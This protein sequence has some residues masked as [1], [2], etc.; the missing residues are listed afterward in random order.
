MLFVAPDEI[1]LEKDLASIRSQFP[2]NGD[3][4][5]PSDLVFLPFLPRGNLCDQLPCLFLFR[6]GVLCVF[7]IHC[8]N[9]RSG[10]LGC[11]VC[12]FAVGS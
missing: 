7:L 3:R 2:G 12:L 1:I 9:V 11:S 6:D 8:E 5:M 10:L 4:G